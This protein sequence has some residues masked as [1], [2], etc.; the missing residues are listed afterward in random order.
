MVPLVAVQLGRLVPARSHVILPMDTLVALIV[1]TEGAVYL[2][3]GVLMLGV[4]KATAADLI[5]DSHGHSQV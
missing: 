5:S 1:R 3:T 4:S 2:A